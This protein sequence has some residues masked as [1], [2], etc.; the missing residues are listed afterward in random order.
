MNKSN[1]YSDKN[2][3][4]HVFKVGRFEGD[5]GKMY[6][7]WVY[8]LDLSQAFCYNGTITTSKWL[9]YTEIKKAIKALGKIPVYHRN[10]WGYGISNDDGGKL[11]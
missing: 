7:G 9:A 4:A 6:D 10:P 11:R 8:N 1:N 3:F 2:Q 5:S